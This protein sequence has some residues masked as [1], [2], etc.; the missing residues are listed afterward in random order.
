MKIILLILIA[1]AYA[2]EGGSMIRIKHDIE[3][4]FGIENATHFFFVAEVPNN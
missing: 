3:F 1:S 2:H 4:G